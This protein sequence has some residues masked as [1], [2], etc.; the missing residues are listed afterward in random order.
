[1]KRLATISILAL[2][3]FPLASSAVQRTYDGVVIAGGGPFPPT[4]QDIQNQVFTPSCA[5]SFCHGAAQSA[6]LDLRAGVSYAMIVN[7]PSTELPSV[8]RIEPFAPDNS[9]LICK[10]EN[11]PWIVG[12]QMPLIGGPLD[13]AVI[14][15]IREWVTLGAYEL[16]PVAVEPTSWGRVK[17]IYK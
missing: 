11:C 2:V 7:H 9:F 15:V 6:G 13:P 8:D 3:V 5:M 12:Q 17:S 4:F 1:M 16:P 14:G 10:L